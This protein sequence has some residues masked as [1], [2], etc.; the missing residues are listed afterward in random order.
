MLHRCLLYDRALP[1][2]SPLLRRVRSKL[3][4][5]TPLRENAP[6]AEE[7]ILLL[8][9]LTHPFRTTRTLLERA[10]TRARIFSLG[11]ETTR[12]R[13]QFL[14]AESLAIYRSSDASE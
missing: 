5:P 1:P 13:N 10:H 7:R 8:R 14:A 2:P 9:I 12:D 3:E 4:Q 6:R 11:D